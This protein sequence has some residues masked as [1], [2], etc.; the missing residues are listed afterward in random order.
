M[1]SEFGEGIA[2][3][4]AVNGIRNKRTQL[5]AYVVG[6]LKDEG[7]LNGSYAAIV[8]KMGIADE[9][10]QFSTYM[11]KG[12]KQPYAEWVKEYVARGIIAL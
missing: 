6:L 11:S 10:R 1:A 5:K 9:K 12:K 7:V 8:K 2:R 4:W 3:Q